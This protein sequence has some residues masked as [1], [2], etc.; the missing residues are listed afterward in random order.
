[1]RHSRGYTL[2]EILIALFIFAI[3]SAIVVMA[4]SNVFTADKSQTSKLKRLS[5]VQLAITLLERDLQ[6]IINRKIIDSAGNKMNAIHI[7]GIKARD[8]IEFTR[9]GFVNPL[10]LQNRS[11]LQR[12]HYYLDNNALYRATYPVLDQTRSSVKQARLILTDIN[13]LSWIFFDSNNNSY[14]TWPPT[15]KIGSQIPQAI[16]VTVRMNDV[17]TINRLFIMPNYEKQFTAQ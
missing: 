13:S 6:Q 7:H 4:I 8:G 11:S 15:E 16:E 9:A 14:T 2:I 1:M 5:E 10:G 3:L 12:V 17:G